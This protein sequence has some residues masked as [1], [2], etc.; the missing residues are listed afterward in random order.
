DVYQGEWSNGQSHGCGIYSSQDGSKYVGEFK[1]GVKHGF[2]YYQYRKWEA[3]SGYWQNGLLVKASCQTQLPDS[4]FSAYPCKVSIAIQKA[5]Q[6]S[7]RAYKV[8]SVDNRVNK[9]VAT[10]N[11]A[12]NAARVAA[13][14]AVQ[15]RMHKGIDSKTSLQCV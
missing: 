3:Q 14:K 10:A 13:V 6:A 8:K 12:A 9:V 2:G 1:W 5:R 4:L 11:R 7:E 15:T